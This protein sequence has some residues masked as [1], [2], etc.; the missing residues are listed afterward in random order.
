MNLFAKKPK[1]WKE[2]M[3][4]SKATDITQ[5]SGRI[6]DRLSF[7]GIHKSDLACIQEE[8]HHLQQYRTEI[9][10][11]FYQSI[12]SVDSLKQMINHHST[13][14]R[15]K[16]TMGKYLDQFLQAE[17]NEAYV[18]TRVTVGQ[19]HSR[20]HL[21]ADH[22]ICAHHLLVH[23]MIAILMEKLHHQPERMTRTVLAIQKLAAFDQ[24]LIV[25]IYM[26]DTFKSFLFGVSNMLDH[27]TQLDTTGQLIKEMETQ[28][29]ESHSV[30]AATEEMSAS[31]MEVANHSV[32]V[33]EGTDDAVKS[34]EHSQAVINKA[35]GDFQDL[36]DVFQNVLGQVERLHTEIGH[37]QDVVQIIKE[38][39]EQTNLLALNA[40]IE[41]ARAG[42]HG[43]GFSVVASEVRKLAENTKDNI[44]QITANIDSLQHVSNEVTNQLNETGK[45]V[46]QSV[47]NAQL[48][49]Q[50]L[51]KIVS[52][53]QE[54]NFSTTQIAS[55]TEEQ[56]SSVMDI[57]HR[58]SVIYDLS[59]NSQAIAQQTARVV[60]ELSKRMDDYRSSFFGINITLGAKD[61][62]RI[63]KTD[64][65]L[66]KWK[67]YNLLL[68][69][70]SMNAGHV[71]SHEACRLGKWYYGALPEQM[72]ANPVFKRI[73]EPHKA[74]HILAKQAAE[75]Y[76]AGELLA[77]QK[78]FEKLQRASDEVVDLLSQLEKDV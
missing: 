34:A 56:T 43:R 28:I 37:M 3:A 30:S 45:L 18:Q 22:F 47:D 65:L 64:H 26:E 15:L 27:T 66:W 9:V 38:V 51:M 63:A 35:L 46:N 32:K 40:S 75:H 42:E 74:V 53:I 10:D 33:A 17:V 48:A 73:E 25:E 12:I 2:Y 24:Q 5:V 1:S 4:S 8:A 71:M 19:V 58:N 6:K 78:A 68:G 50:E 31:I 62:I 23:A 52:T 77:A 55:M 59:T 72:K 49:D 29:E 11:T 60:L 61:T 69:L 16:Q 14:D 54:I 13:L 57:A 21:T 44:A 76:E 41:A 20:I 70:E 7:L 67:V 39:A 36:G